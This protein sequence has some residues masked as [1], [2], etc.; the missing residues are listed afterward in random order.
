MP[1]GTNVL[2]RWVG[3]LGGIAR[4]GSGGRGSSSAAYQHRASTYA[5]YAPKCPLSQ[6]PSVWTLTGR[7]GTSVPPVPMDERALFPLLTD[8]IAIKLAHHSLVLFFVFL[9]FR[10][11]LYIASGTIV[12]VGAGI[13]AVAVP[14]SVVY[15]DPSRHCRD[16]LRSFSRPLRW[17][18]V[19]AIS[20]AGLSCLV[21]LFS[22]LVLVMT[23]SVKKGKRSR[24]SM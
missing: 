24:S 6:Q 9:D 23:M 1:G 4:R 11:Y 10:S 2:L 8:T 20:R 16:Q 19:C 3:D 5:L 22:L 17:S 15:T 13:A 14:L 12:P 21:A 18:S 7:V